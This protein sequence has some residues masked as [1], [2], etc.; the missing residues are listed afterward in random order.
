MGAFR[1]HLEHGLDESR[2]L[3]YAI[4]LSYLDHQVS[5]APKAR[6]STMETKLT[7]QCGF[8]TRPNFTPVLGRSLRPLQCDHDLLSAHW[9]LHAGALAA[10]QLLPFTCGYH[11][12]RACVRLFQ[13]RI[14]FFAHAMC[15]EDGYS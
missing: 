3:T 14:R 12:L 15:R 8:N 10:L 6:R 13:R 1:L 9:R 11:R 4:S 5:I 2:L 7:D